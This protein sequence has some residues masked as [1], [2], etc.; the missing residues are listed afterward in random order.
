MISRR[1]LPRYGAWLGL[2]AGGLIGLAGCSGPVALYHQAE[3]GA[4]AQDRQPPPG[5]DEPYP[6]LAA[7]PAA[8]A[9]V[10]PLQQVVTNMRLAG[11]YPGV[12]GP[13]PGALAG[14]ELPTAPPPVPPVPGLDIPAVPS[15]AL[16]PMAPA[17]VPRVLPPSAPVALAFA[18]GSAVLDTTAA[19]ALQGLALS[20]GQARLLVGGFGEAGVVPGNAGAL[21]LAVARAARLAAALTADGVPPA[22]V[23]MVAAATGSGG[24]VQLVY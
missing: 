17:P 13:S 14:L 5:A 3:G 12:S 1:A 7:V 23:W 8:P 9:A 22:A 20:R 18:P 24:F 2:L 16:L 6:N 19:V 21:R 4:I 15:T 10:T 11:T